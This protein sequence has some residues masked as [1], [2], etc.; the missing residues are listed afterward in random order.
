MRSVV[1]CVMAR[2]FFSAVIFVHM[3]T[4]LLACILL[5]LKDPM[6]T[7]C[8]PFVYK[9]YE[10]NIHQISHCDVKD[11]KMLFMLPTWSYRGPQPLLSPCSLLCLPGFLLLLFLFLFLEMSLCLHLTL[12][13]SLCLFRSPSISFSQRFSLRIHCSWFS[14]LVLS[15]EL[16]AAALIEPRFQAIF[17]ESTTAVR[18]GMHK[19]KFEGR[20]SVD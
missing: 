7:G 18:N 20:K 11:I 15:I 5:W 12:R 16:A 8:A 9:T 2:G 19:S 3:H 10:V 6:T 17:E 1:M 4:I 14:F 13:R